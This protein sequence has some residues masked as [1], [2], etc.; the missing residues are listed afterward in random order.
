[1]TEP[2]HN[3]PT[4][5]LVQLTLDHAGTSVADLDRSTRFYVEVFGFSVEERFAIPNSDVRGAVLVHPGGARIELFHRPGSRPRPTGHPI[6]S[7]SDQGWFQTAFRVADVADV[8][9]RV[10]AAG[11][12]AVKEPFVA[13]DGRSHVAFVG[14]PD[15]NLIELI[16][17]DAVN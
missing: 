16:R 2:T 11:A 17:R 6:E 15:G 14:D 3:R 8:F 7:T 10:V 5:S 13:P 1:M 4:G 12:S 9:S